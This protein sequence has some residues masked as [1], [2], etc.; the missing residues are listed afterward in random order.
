MC[1]RPGSTLALRSESA[2]EL[3]RLQ[4]RGGLRRISSDRGGTHDSMYLI[5]AAATVGNS[6]DQNAMSE[7]CAPVSPR[8]IRRWRSE[9]RPGRLGTLAKNCGK[10]SPRSVSPS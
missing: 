9:L 6:A 7:N 3:D 4:I 8:S 2:G 10:V 5:A 1:K